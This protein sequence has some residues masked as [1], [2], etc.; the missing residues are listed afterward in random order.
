MNLQYIKGENVTIYCNIQ[1]NYIVD[2]ILTYYDTVQ[3][4]GVLFYVTLGYCIDNIYDLY[5]KIIFYNIEHVCGYSDDYYKAF[6]NVIN[7]CIEKNILVEFWDFDIMNYRKLLQLM[8]KLINYY[9]FKPLRF[10]E[11][12]RVE[13]GFKK[14]DAIQIGG[15]RIACDYRNKVFYHFNELDIKNAYNSSFSMINIERSKYSLSELYDEINSANV[16]LNIPRLVTNM[17]EQLRLGQL[18]SMN[19]I[20]ATQTFGVP[21]LSDFVTE[22]DFMS[23][24]IFDVLKNMN[25]VCNVAD[26]FKEQTFT[27]ESYNMYIQLCLKKW[28]DYTKA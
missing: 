11:Y 3:Y 10:V 12:K 24:D 2:N 6:A 18:I 28:Y 14:Y 5:D 25:T 4:K 1:Y 13:D 19:C 27:E 26:K 15:T 21:Y 8:P 22:V 16:V 17:Q 20:V 23:D 9:K 7:T